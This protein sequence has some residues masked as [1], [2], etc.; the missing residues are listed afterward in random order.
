MVMKKFIND[1]ANLTAELLEGFALESGKLVVRARPKDP[2]KVAL[3][4]LGG[5]GHEPALSG[6]VG[7]GM[8]DISVVGDIFAAPGPPKVL[9]ALRKADRPAGVLLVVLNHAGDVMSAN[10]A[11]EMARKQGLNVRMVLTHED[12]ARG[13]NAPAGDRRGLV[14]AIPLYKIAGAAAEAGMD[15][16]QVC[17]IAER[18]NA[19]MATLAV[20]MKTATH[21]ATGQSIFELA[22]DQMEV[23]MG[24]HG[25]PGTGPSKLLTADQTAEVMLERL[26]AA[27]D[28]RS[29]DRLLVLL[30]GSGATTLMELFIVYRAVHAKLSARGIQ[31]V[32]PRIGEFL[33]VQ[34]MAGFQMFLAKLDDELIRLWNAPADTPYFTVR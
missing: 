11:L 33:T 13:A 19:R 18:L 17:A 5:A 34:E 30:N 4:T 32:A 1:P 9:E 15:L 10:L 12:I 22:D 29:G 14:G 8:L 24:Q 2:G 3:V 21:P 20:A 16:D 27:V 6:F 31:A 28:A 26:L 25:E 23:G 7:E